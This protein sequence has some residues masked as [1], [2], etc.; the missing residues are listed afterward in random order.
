MYSIDK[1]LI[2]EIT[3]FIFLEDAI[4]DIKPADAIFIPGCARPEH[5]EE[6]A[7]LYRE[8]YA[9]LVIPSGGYTK[10][11]GGFSGIKAGGERYGTDYSCE[12]DFL[13][14]VLMANGVPERA[15]L[16]EREATYTLENAEKSRDLLAARGLLGGI[17]SAVICC[18][19]YHARRCHMYYHMVFPD[20]D[21]RI[22]P[23]VIDGV[24]RE[25]W[26]KDPAGRRIVLS[27]FSRTGQQ[28]LMMEGRLS[29]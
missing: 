19:A 24:S 12:A 7:R 10:L 23:V 26:Y 15:I 3:D 16:T 6:A 17:R 11:E 20:V 13:K 2:S 27:E 9:P 22:H 14:A 28:L 25:D 5:T 29:W 4:E 1:T 18:K 21:F 8:G